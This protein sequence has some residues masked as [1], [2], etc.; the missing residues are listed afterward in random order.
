MSRKALCII[1]LGS[2]DPELR[3]RFGDF[4]HWIRAGLNSTDQQIRIIDVQKGQALA[5]PENC[6]GAVLSGS[7]A[8]ATD[9]AGWSLRTE[10]WLKDLLHA[11]VPVL[12]ICYGHHLLARAAGGSVGYHPA[13][14]EIGTVDIRLFAES[15]RTDPLFSSAP[16]R[17]AGHATHFQTVLRLPPGAVH[18]AESDHDPH[19][20]FRVGPCAWGVQFH[21]E[22]NEN[23]MRAYIRKQAGELTREGRNPE[24]LLQNVGPAP[25]AAQ[26][27]SAFA[28]LVQS[29]IPYQGLD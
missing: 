12:G 19:H 22:F 24:Q 20:A 16:A 26:I 17:F 8:M 6:A 14:R 1:K 23:I 9:A 18:L 13:G 4:E 7:H 25:Q 11:R 29:P 28:R 10:H 5:G 2:T 21:P 3:A 27:L 15:A